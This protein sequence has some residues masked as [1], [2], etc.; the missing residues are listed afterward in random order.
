MEPAFKKSWQARTSTGNYFEMLDGLRG[1]AILMVVAYHTFYTNP[2]SHVLVRFIG[3][4]ILL[5][6]RTA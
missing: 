6:L 3:G 5:N 2:E 4:M 1:I